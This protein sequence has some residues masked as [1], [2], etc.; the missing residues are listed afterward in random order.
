MK[1]INF[2]CL[3][4]DGFRYNSLYSSDK[5]GNPDGCACKTPQLREKDELFAFKWPN[6]PERVQGA[7]AERIR[8]MY[9]LELPHEDV[10]RIFKCLVARDVEIPMPWVEV[11][12]GK[13]PP[14]RKFRME[15]FNEETFETEIKT[16]EEPSADKAEDVYYAHGYVGTLGGRKWLRDG[17]GYT[18]FQAWNSNFLTM[19][20]GEARLRD[21]KKAESICVSNARRALLEYIGGAVRKGNAAAR[22]LKRLDGYDWTKKGAV[23]LTKADFME[24]PREWDDRYPE[25]HN[26]DWKLQEAIKKY[27]LSNE[28]NQAFIDWIASGCRT[29]EAGAKKSKLSTANC[30]VATAVDFP[31]LTRGNVVDCYHGLPGDVIE[32][33][34]PGD[35]FTCGKGGT[36]YVVFRTAVVD[37]EKVIAYAKAGTTIDCEGFID[38]DDIR[39]GIAEESIEDCW[40]CLFDVNRQGRRKKILKVR[41]IEKAVKGNDGE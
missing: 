28:V 7:A 22:V 38:R 9:G 30:S 21:Y 27:G 15:T 16:V 11:E 4:D 13:A 37:G 6:L 12:K 14:P 18:M 39:L 34:R 25:W 36:K 10:L 5:L 20:K 24:Q 32:K 26:V 1:E 19:D 29:T 2:D 3:K 8:Q 35:A 17:D 23:K 31:E 40:D 41:S 33:L